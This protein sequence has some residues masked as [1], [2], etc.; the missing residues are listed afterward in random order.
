MATGKLAAQFFQQPATKQD[1]Q[2]AVGI[3]GAEK[4]QDQNLAV[5]T[6]SELNR[7]SF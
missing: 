2:V 7:K 5:K 3:Q 4:R 6:K 1:G